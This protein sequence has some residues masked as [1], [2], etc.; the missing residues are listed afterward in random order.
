[1]ENKQPIPD[2]LE[3]LKPEGELVFDDDNSEVG[4]ENDAATAGFQSNEPATAVDE[5]AADGFAEPV[6]VPDEFS[7]SKQ[8]T[9]APAAADEFSW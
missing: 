2:F 3:E 4:E 8:E 7:A 5:F 6:A 9:E 1:M